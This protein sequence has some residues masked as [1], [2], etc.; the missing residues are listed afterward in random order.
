MI[1]C[2]V[3]GSVGKPVASQIENFRN[4]CFS[5]RCRKR[6][7]YLITVGPGSNIGRGVGSSILNPDDKTV[8]LHN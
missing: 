3:S 7:L 1:R 8:A 2:C 5:G 6:L 4:R